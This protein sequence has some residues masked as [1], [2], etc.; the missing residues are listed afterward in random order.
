MIDRTNWDQWDDQGSRDWRARA[1]DVID[2][3]LASYELEPLQESSTPKSRISSNDRAKTEAFTL[4]A[5]D[6]DG[7]CLDYALMNQLLFEGKHEPS[8]R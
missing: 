2:E 8:R 1:N 5:F 3:T 7:A 4:P 6:G